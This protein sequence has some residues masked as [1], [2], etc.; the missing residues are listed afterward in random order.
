MIFITCHSRF[1]ALGPVDAFRGP[2]WPEARDGHHRSKDE[3]DQ[4]SD[5]SR[6]VG[7]EV[8]TEVNR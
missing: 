7:E 4:Y 1:G 8:E 6:L 2:F 5:H 3:K